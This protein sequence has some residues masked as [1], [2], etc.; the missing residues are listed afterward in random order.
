MAG[1]FVL[2]AISAVAALIAIPFLVRFGGVDGWSAVAIGQGVGATT[3]LIVTFG[4]GTSGPAQVARA[5][6]ATLGHI[7]WA[8]ICMRFGVLILIL[9]LGLIVVRALAQ[10][11]HATALLVCAAV[12]VQGM[13]AGWYLTGLHR[14]FAIAALETGPRAAAQIA[15]IAVVASTGDLLWYGVITL[16]VEALFASLSAILIARPQSVA[17]TVRDVAT[18]VRQQWPLVI[19]A[20]ASALYTRAATPIV[21]AVSPMAVPIFAAADRVQQF[22][23]TGLRPIAM[24]FQGWVAAD[25]GRYR[26]RARVASLVTAGVGI[27]IG[28]VIAAVLPYASPILFSNAFHF[29]WTQSFAIGILLASVA[30]SMSTGLYYLIP[31]GAVSVFSWTAGIASALGVPLLVLL[32]TVADASGA[33]VALATVEALVFISQ[34]VVAARLIKRLDS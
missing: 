15:A 2:P 33:L 3:A 4:W 32:A 13:T 34:A 26:E 18:Q 30:G 1:F 6:Q 19:S 27:A 11:E 28:A 8:S 5:P 7:Y 23:R 25:M 12:T 16:G 9:P 31:L 10:A 17:R 24:F 14:P 20:L 29:S 21:A 22:G